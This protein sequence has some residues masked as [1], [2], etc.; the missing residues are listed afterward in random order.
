MGRA[1]SFYVNGRPAWAENRWA[2][3]NASAREIGRIGFNNTFG[4][5]SK[6]LLDGVH[7]LY[8]RSF[9]SVVGGAV[10]CV[11]INPQDAQGSNLGAKIVCWDSR[12]PTGN[13]IIEIGGSQVRSS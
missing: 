9:T 5:G 4:E 2:A 1:E 13:Q 8:P 12:L 6:F 7:I 10:H 11:T 3:V